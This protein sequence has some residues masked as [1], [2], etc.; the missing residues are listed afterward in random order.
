MGD[1]FL[2]S[3][4][5]TQPSNNDHTVLNS[6]ELVNRL[7]ELVDVDDIEKDDV[8]MI[9][10]DLLAFNQRRGSAHF[11]HMLPLDHP[12]SIYISSPRKHQL[13]RIEQRILRITRR[14]FHL[15]FAYK[16]AIYWLM[17]YIFLRGPVETTLKRQLQKIMVSPQQIAYT[18]IGV[19]ATVAAA[20]SA[21]F[22]N[23]LEANRRQ[24]HM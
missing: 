1:S 24:S 15:S 11:P 9:S 10:D 12:H 14:L 22:T 4:F 23:S 6:I 3:F 21:S 19:T 5:T 17:L 13:A 8:D 20:M 18:T 2:T 7:A 16:G